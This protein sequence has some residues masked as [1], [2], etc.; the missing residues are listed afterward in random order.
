MW[1]TGRIP[2]ILLWAHLWL[3]SLHTSQLTTPSIGQ[4][5]KH[6]SLDISCHFLYT[7]T[8]FLLCVWV[9][10][11]QPLSLNPGIASQA[12]LETACQSGGGSQMQCVCACLA[13][14]N[15]KHLHPSICDLSPASSFPLVLSGCQP[16]EITHRTSEQSSLSSASVP[17]Y[18]FFILPGSHLIHHY[19]SSPS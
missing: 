16:S 13:R 5:L 14:G 6:S 3:L 10:L 2:V 17:L 9:T 1:P 11:T 8:Q 12:L 7:N 18:T 19:L 4:F 15:E